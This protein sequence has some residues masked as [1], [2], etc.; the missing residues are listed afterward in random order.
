MA[1]CVLR[2]SKERLVDLSCGQGEGDRPAEHELGFVGDTSRFKRGSRNHSHPSWVWKSFGA[3]GIVQMWGWNCTED[4]GSHAWE[5]RNILLGMGMGNFRISCSHKRVPMLW[6]LPGGQWEVGAEKFLSRE[7][8]GG[9][10]GTGLGK[11]FPH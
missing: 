3:D 2:M 10:Q 4:D 11:G 7:F 9:I 1:N 5:L 8:R 6:A